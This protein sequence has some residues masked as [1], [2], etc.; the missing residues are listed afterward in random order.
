MRGSFVIAMA[1]L[2][3]LSASCEEPVS[4]EITVVVDSNLLVPED[5]DRLYLLVNAPGDPERRVVNGTLSETGNAPFPRTVV[6]AHQSGPLGPISLRVEG[7]LSSATQVAQDLSF[8]FRPEQSLMLRVNLLSSCLGF[9]CSP[10]DTCRDGEC[11]PIEVPSDY[12]EPWTGVPE[13]IGS[14]EPDTLD[15]SL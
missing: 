4:T 3:G 15:A 13:P 9:P 12:L 8:S 7:R 5:I 1:L 10:P 14:R 11:V 6:L 2:A